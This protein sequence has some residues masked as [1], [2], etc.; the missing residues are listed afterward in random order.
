MITKTSQSAIRVLVFLAQR[1]P[2]TIFSP[3]RMAEELGESPTYLAK[4][5]GHMV[6]AGILRAVKGV[7]GGVQLN[8]DPDRVSLLDVVEACQGHIVGDYCRA[9]LNI[10]LTCAYHHAAMELYQA[11]VG[12]LGRWSLADLL[13]QPGP[14]RI[15]P[16][17]VCVLT[18]AC[19]TQPA[20]REP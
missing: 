4:V 13:M 15:Q 7:K 18:G 3:K 1:G 11:I 5:T 2:G 14:L 9:S 8:R 10:Q 17:H 20:V 16:G 19:Q 12:V 6:R